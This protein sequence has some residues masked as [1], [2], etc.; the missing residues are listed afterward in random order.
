MKGPFQTSF[1]S[2]GISLERVSSCVLYGDQYRWAV[3]LG[4]LI[5]FEWSQYRILNF[6]Q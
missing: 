3:L 2:Q 1:V 6:K 5:S 4:G